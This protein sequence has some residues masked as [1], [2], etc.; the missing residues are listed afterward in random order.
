MGIFKR[1]NLNKEN[2]DIAG[3]NFREV[4]ITPF[5]TRRDRLI[6][7]LGQMAFTFLSTCAVVYMLNDTVDMCCKNWIIIV[8][9]LLSQ[10]ILYPA[11]YVYTIKGV[12]KY[13]AA[14]FAIFVAGMIIFR[15]QIVE[16][17]LYMVDDYL[18]V[19]NEYIKEEYYVDYN[20]ELGKAY[21][22][23]AF[24]IF[25]I[26]LYTLLFDYIIMCNT[27]R[28]L[29]I[30][31]TLPV[32]MLPFFVG[33]TPGTMAFSI[34]VCMVASLIGTTTLKKK[35]FPKNIRKKNTVQRMLY[36]STYM[37]MI[38]T[39]GCLF[40]LCMVVVALFLPRNLYD[41]EVL[42]KRH[43]EFLMDVQDKTDEIGGRFETEFGWIDDILGIDDYVGPADRE[44]R[45]KS[46]EADALTQ[47][48]RGLADG[49]IKKKTTDM[50]SYL[51]SKHQVNTGLFYGDFAHGKLDN[52]SGKASISTEEMLKIEYEG[53]DY[54]NVDEDIYLRTFSS[55]QYNNGVW[56]ATSE[57][58]TSKYQYLELEQ[59]FNDHM[60]RSLWI[61][62]SYT[63][64][65]TKQ[66]NL[67]DMIE[68]PYYMNEDMTLEDGGNKISMDMNKISRIN[69]IQNPGSLFAIRDELFTTDDNLEKARNP[70][71]FWD[72]DT[73][74]EDIMAMQGEYG[75]FQTLYDA[76]TYV[77]EG[78][79]KIKE[80]IFKKTAGELITP[81]E[82]IFR[83]DEASYYEYYVDVLCAM[84]C[85]DEMLEEEYTYT[86]EPQVDSNADPIEYFM[87]ES[88]EGYC[89][90][91]ASAATIM[92]RSLGIP[93]RYVEGF[94]VESS[95]FGC[96]DTDNGVFRTTAYGTNAHAWIEVY[97]KGL[98]WVPQE[99]T[100]GRTKEDRSFMSEAE[101]YRREHKTEPV[102]TPAPTENV[103]V[104]PTPTKTQT[105]SIPGDNNNKATDTP[106]A[107]ASSDNKEG[108]DTVIEDE[109]EEVKVN[110]RVICI[111]LAA[112][113]NICICSIIGYGIHRRNL[114]NARTVKRMIRKY[115]YITAFFD[116]Q[117]KKA[118]VDITNDMSYEEYAKAFCEKIEY[119]EY[120]KMLRVMEVR[121]RVKFSEDRI[122]DEDCEVL[123]D[124]Y[125]GYVNKWSQDWG[126]LKRFYMT[127][128]HGVIEKI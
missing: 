69:N 9:M 15:R 62:D 75:E 52:Y 99:V 51:L 114:K 7:M 108:N 43:K 44:M 28:L 78:M 72:A 39:S 38:M 46:K 35:M 1:K 71:F 80:K 42:R 82:K 77:P 26:W 119:I 81:R 24:I 3:F 76:Y 111:I 121:S 18:A 107:T 23:T 85:I 84:E 11:M 125:N 41:H 73:N 27:S 90:H 36:D 40:A 57:D 79:E 66:S 50:A 88:K 123:S 48:L 113:F 59:M 116:E 128:I 103:S 14:A 127:K 6:V 5:D 64:T 19:M 100:L 86:L 74:E 63:M 16:G 115:N 93:A 34:Y 67:K 8:T 120:E 105:S 31:I 55:Q 106:K 10:L 98:G 89:M 126:R 109:H 49:D 2:P 17:M 112:V 83:Q 102:K 110:Y 12:R 104:T 22:V 61:G 13:V 70:V 29:Y 53:Y 25:V 124:A 21:A 122:C 32:V 92:L 56:E 45:D 47:W 117:G 87:I 91:F 4:K 101:R 68:I 60:K 94:C 95:K 97:L 65:V 96:T 58:I 30:I 33:K 37:K 54:L 20:Y 118:G